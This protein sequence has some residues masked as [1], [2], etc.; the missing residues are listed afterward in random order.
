MCSINTQTKIII[1]KLLMLSVILLYQNRLEIMTINS[2]HNK[3]CY[4]QSVID[5]VRLKLVILYKIA[6]SQWILLRNNAS[7]LNFV[8]KLVKKLRKLLN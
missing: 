6:N 3:N 2:A 5:S 7:V 8:S 4:L 1:G